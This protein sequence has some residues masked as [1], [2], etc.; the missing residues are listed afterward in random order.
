MTCFTLSQPLS[1]TRCTEKAKLSTERGRQT[2]FERTKLEKIEVDPPAAKRHVGKQKPKVVDD[3]QGGSPRKKV[4]VSY[5]QQEN[6]DE[7]ELDKIARERNLEPDDDEAQV[8]ES[9][10]SA[11]ARARGKQA[12]FSKS[13]RGTR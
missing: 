12:R 7:D 3:S 5:P 1:A 6:G 9:K 8:I 13:N 2:D 10:S 4:V 11:P